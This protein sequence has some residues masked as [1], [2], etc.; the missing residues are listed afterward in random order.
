MERLVY[1]GINGGFIN[2]ILG[3]TEIEE[4]ASYL[5]VY[6]PIEIV[7]IHLRKAQFV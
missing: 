2:D 5:L 1:W 3:P 6:A 7:T 4:K